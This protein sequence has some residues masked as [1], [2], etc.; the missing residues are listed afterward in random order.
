MILT[1]DEEAVQG[2][3]EVVEVEV[4]VEVEAEM[5]ILTPH[6]RIDQVLLEVDDADAP[7]NSSTTLRWNNAWPKFD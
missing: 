2:V 3:A 7:T 5:T 6:L 4:E 1:V